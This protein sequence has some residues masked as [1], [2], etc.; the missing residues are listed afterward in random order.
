MA[1]IISIG[2]SFLLFFVVLGFM[3]LIGVN[4]L[5]AIFDVVD[6]QVAHNDPGNESGW[7]A[8]KDSLKQNIQLVMLWAVPILTLFASI[9]MLANAGGKGRE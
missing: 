9:K 4:L 2:V 3:W 7:V 1:S 6:D 8:T 5:S